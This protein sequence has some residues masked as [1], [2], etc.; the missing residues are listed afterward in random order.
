[1]HFKGLPWDF[2]HKHFNLM[3]G[4]GGGLW[5][6]YCGDFY[7]QKILLNRMGVENFSVRWGENLTLEHFRDNI[8]NGGLF[9]TNKDHLIYNSERLCREVKE[10][11]LQ[12]SPQ[13]DSRIL[14]CF[15]K[16]EKFFDKMSQVSGARLL[17][18]ES[19][20]FWEGEKTINFLSE[21]MKLRLSGG[22]K[23]YLL[24]ALP[25]KVSDF[26]QVLKFLSLNVSS[27]TVLSQG[28]VEDLVKTR[29]LNPFHLADMLSLKKF[30]EFYETLVEKRFDFDTYRSI[31]SFMQT[32]LLKLG[33]PEYAKKKSRLSQYDRNILLH[34]KNWSEDEVD[35][36]LKHMGEWEILAKKRSSFLYTR[37]RCYHI[38]L[39]L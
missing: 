37:L 26:V 28:Q 17:Q 21:Q 13:E 38:N 31:F 34:S 18:I 35:T 36:Q 30:K 7:L 32:H 19:P 2:V 3:K 22:A 20:R 29:E 5:G 24:D 6:F 14:L 12:H 27:E 33:E 1:M 15:S 25:N 23:S 9:T 8:V 16:K 10:A 11:V 4:L 39:L